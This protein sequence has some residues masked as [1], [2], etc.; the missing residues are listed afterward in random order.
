MTGPPPPLPPYVVV[1][2]PDANCT[3]EICD[4]HYSLYRYRPNIAV[5]ALFLAL[6][7][8][9]GLVHI[10]LGI[11]WR[12]Y[13]FMTFMVLGC[14]SEIVGYIGRIMLYHNPFAFVPFMLQIVFITSGPVWY[15]AAIYVTLSKAI[16]HLGPELARLPPK[17]LYWVFIALDVS[18]LVIQAAGG[19]ISTDSKG[20][21]DL[22]VNLAMGGLVIQVV[23]IVVFCAVF[24][25]YMIRYTRSS[26]TR[27]LTQREKIFFGF[28]ALAVALILARCS[29]RVDELS[30][31]YS[32]STKVTD[33][34]LFIGLE[35]VLIV[36][37]VFSLCLGHPGLVFENKTERAEERKE[38]QASVESAMS[39]TTDKGRSR[40]VS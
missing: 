34:G 13:W 3:L 25:D 12:S 14:L 19:A 7:G 38:S 18:C 5:N 2:G 22:G 21:S 10:F 37:A 29:Y 24:A 33:E 39:E 6:Y 20:D 17:A 8:I 26:Y 40:H 23:V 4:I 1:F 27:K 9:A 32:N 16:T 30:E 35:G 15:T 11:R 28:L 36:L 31:G